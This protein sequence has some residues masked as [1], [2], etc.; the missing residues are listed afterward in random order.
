MKISNILLA[1]DF[2][3]GALHAL[4][5]AVDF[6]KTSGAK[7]H[8]VHVIYDVALATGMHIPHTSLDVLYKE[9]EDTSRA[10]LEAYALPQ[11]KDIT[12]VVYAVVRGVPHEEILKYATSK[13][14]DLIVIGTHGRTGVDRLFFGSTAERVVRGASCPVLTVRKPA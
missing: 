12:N 6:A 13:G 10:N 3:D 7:L 14:I 8:L 2:S 9:L 5:Y 11:R 1:T 4:P